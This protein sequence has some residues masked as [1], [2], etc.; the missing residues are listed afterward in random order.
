MDI[1]KEK[2]LLTEAELVNQLGLNRT[3]I[4]RARKSGKLGH[5]KLGGRVLYSAA[6]VNEFLTAHEK[7]ASVRQE[8]VK[9]Q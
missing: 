2:L 5:Y 3:T 7:K 1:G 9:E 8:G 6:Q 4:W